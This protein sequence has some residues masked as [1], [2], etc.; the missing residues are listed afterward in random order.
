[1]AQTAKATNRSF[2]HSNEL[3][4]TQNNLIIATSSFLFVDYFL[5]MYYNQLFI[6]SHQKIFSFRGF[7]K[8]MIKRNW[9]FFCNFAEEF[10]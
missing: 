1:L 5:F 2:L 6:D 3:K 10:E 4:S 7:N 8:D 9:L